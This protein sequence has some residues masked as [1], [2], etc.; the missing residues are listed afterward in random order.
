MNFLSI[1]ARN[2]TCCR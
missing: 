1:R 2:L